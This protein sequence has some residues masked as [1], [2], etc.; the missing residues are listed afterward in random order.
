MIPTF[1]IVKMT[2]VIEDYARVISPQMSRWI[3]PEP[4]SREAGIPGC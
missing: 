2:P 1:S 3:K 4:A